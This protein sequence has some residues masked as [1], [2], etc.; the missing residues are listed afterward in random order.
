M[1]DI[2]DELT[3]ARHDAAG[4]QTQKAELL[5]VYQEA[6]AERLDQPFFYPERFWKR[7]EGYASRDGFSLATGRVGGELAGFTL[8]ETLPKGTGWWQD[9]KGDVDPE[10]LQETGSRTFAINELM[11]RPAWRRRG[12]AK[13]LS[14]ALLEGRPEERATL[15]VRAENR[16]AYT[17]YLSWGFRVIGQVQPF[18]DSPVYEAMVKELG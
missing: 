12:Y 2:P 8:G 4:M 9:F 3:L 11:V 6:Y 7:L 14:A 1:A 10:L 15:L 18:D 5:S 16:P 13:V 17:A